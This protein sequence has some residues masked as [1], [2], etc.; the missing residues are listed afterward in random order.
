MLTDAEVVEELT[1]AGVTIA[2]YFLIGGCPHCVNRHGQ[3]LGVAADDELS[4]AMVAYLHRVGVAEY[5]SEEA[6]RAQA[7]RRTP[8]CS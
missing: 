4:E 3:L 2:D 7:E 5:P 6:Y 8:R 1:G